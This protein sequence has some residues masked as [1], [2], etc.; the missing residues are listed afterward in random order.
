MVNHYLTNQTN[1]FITTDVPEGLKFFQ[2]AQK[3]G[4][5]NDF[6]TSDYRHKVTTRFSLGC[7]DVRGVFGSGNAGS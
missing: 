1:W 2:R 3:S 4:S 5:D 7:T 6:N